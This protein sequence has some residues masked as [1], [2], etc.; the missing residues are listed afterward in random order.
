MSS[1]AYWEHNTMHEALSLCTDRPVVG[2]L[3]V[4]INHT[5]AHSLPTF[6]T[7][8]MPGFSI[9]YLAPAVLNLCLLGVLSQCPVIELGLIEMIT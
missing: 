3:L 6:A 8:H 1:G 5:S 2:M 4:T 7:D 9:I